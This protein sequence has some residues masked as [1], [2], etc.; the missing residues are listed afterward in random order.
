MPFCCSYRF[1]FSEEYRKVQESY[2]AMVRTHDPQNI[3]RILQR[4]P[5]HVD[6]LLQLSEVNLA[7][8]HFE[9]AAELVKRALHVS[10]LVVPDQSHL[11]DGR[12]F[13]CC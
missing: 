13:L 3:M 6:S 5:F 4:N 8:G 2:L 12:T 10:R 11:S 7:M 1:E 9:Q